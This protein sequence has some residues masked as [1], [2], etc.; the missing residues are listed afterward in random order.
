MGCRMLM[1]LAG[2]IAAISQPMA[3][4]ANELSLPVDAGHQEIETAATTV[5]EW[6]V[7]IAQTTIQIIGVQ[8]E[9]TDDG[10]R[11]ILETAGGE[12]VAPVTQTVGNALIADIPNAVL[13]LP[14]GGEFQQANPAASIALVTVAPSGD[15]V[16]VA[17]T[18]AD[19]PP[20]A[21][22]SATAQGLSLSVV[23]GLEVAETSDE[24][25]QVVVTGEQDEDYA[26][27]SASTATRT[28]TPLR[29]IPQ[30]IQ[31]VPRQVIEDQGVTR[32]GDALRNVSGVT[33]Q[34]G[35]GGITDQFTIRG[36][37]DTSTFRNGF[38]QTGLLGFSP[39]NSP[40]TIE[41][42]EVLKGPASIMFGQI[43]PGGV[44][45]FITRMPLS[46]PFY[47]AEFTAGQFS[48]YE[49]F[50]DA[51]G[52]LT[53][54]GRLLYRLGATY[55]NFGSF[56]DFV[57]GENISIAPV[58]SYQISDST[59]LRADYEFFNTSETF[60]DGLPLDP[61]VF[62]LPNSRFLGEPDNRI[63]STSH[64]IGLSIEHQFNENID[65]RSTFT[66]FIANENSRA[67]RLFDLIPGTQEIERTSRENS[68]R[69]E[70][71]AWQ[72]DLITRFNTGSI[73][74]QLL[75]GLEFASLSGSNS[76]IESEIFPINVVN[77]IYR[78]PIPPI[79]STFSRTDSSTRF[80]VLLQDQIEVLP[81]LNLLVGGRYDST[82]I[83]FNLEDIFV[84]EEPF[85]LDGD[86]SDQ[87]FSPRVGVVYQPI[88]PISLYASFSR[89]FQP[90]GAITRRFA[91]DGESVPPT[92]GTQYEIGVRAAITENLSANLALYHITKTNIL[93]T[94]PDD[95]DFIIPIGE[96]RSRGIE[97]D[98]GGE[99]LPGWNVIA[100]AFLNDA[101][102]TEDGDL[103]IGDTLI[104][105][106]R[107]GASLWTTYEIQQ[108]DLQGLG[109]G[110]GLFY[111]GDR[112]A[113]LPNNFVL[114]SYLRTD[115]SI[116]Y[117]RDNWRL[118][119][120]LKN[121]FNTQY[122][123]SA[124]NTGLIYPGAPFSVLGT[125]SVRF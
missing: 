114:P 34:V 95:P 42:I 99:I 17:I 54:D 14:G 55:R 46:E 123:E 39:I 111:V 69:S 78:E 105:A 92:R 11:V 41:R 21:T 116:F 1:G 102:I 62:D 9:P 104:N 7:Q 109:F 28:D 90:N 8:V 31:V 51:S 115:A 60:N 71:Y 98:I 106:P 4:K 24:A 73:K 27:S 70:N 32:I 87:A 125:V 65:L 36:F 59:T 64:R 83:R 77:P 30:S 107:T 79:E 2:A 40:S 49:P 13:A 120:N 12:L 96:A 81:N 35:F 6:L 110:L 58:L 121:L 118:G 63:N 57:N 85:T 91:Q 15:G 88:E 67:A 61:I 43:E 103:P 33:P 52:P 100:S 45:N 26:P 84:G 108:G 20:T 56:V 86:F 47:Q 18:G 76:S 22:V 101:V 75:L 23:P 10:L 5:D 3:V 29:D 89:S 80:G 122:L 113:Q 50:L 72:T 82:N 44:V 117:R 37:T 53:E 97:L 66:A 124:Q 68:F 112:E 16:R 38:R 19:A 94:D 48:F 93:T 74:H 25:I 119:V